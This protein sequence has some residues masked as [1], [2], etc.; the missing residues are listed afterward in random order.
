METNY[1]LILTF[2]LDAEMMKEKDIIV[3]FTESVNEM[4]AEKNSNVFPIDYQVL[5]QRIKMANTQGS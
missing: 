4:L 3:P 2:Y 5:R 1:P